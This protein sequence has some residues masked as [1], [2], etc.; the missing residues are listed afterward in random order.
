MS[1]KE[2]VKTNGQEAT[3]RTSRGKKLERRY[4]GENK[5]V[6]AKLSEQEL[7]PRKSSGKSKDDNTNLT[8]TE[9]EEVRSPMF[10]S[11]VRITF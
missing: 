6:S 11:Q 3:P 7:G 10:V 2:S 4:T 5:K 1:E 8:L 9:G